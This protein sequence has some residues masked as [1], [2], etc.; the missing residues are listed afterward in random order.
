MENEI[1]KIKI[2]LPFSESLRNS[3]Y[4]A[5]I[6]KILKAEESADI[7]NLEDDHP[8]IMFGPRVESKDNEEVPPFYVSL[9]IHD[10]ILH[11]TMLESNASHNL[12]PNVS[13]IIWD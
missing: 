12:M 1:S 9:R 7:V 6:S 10:Q 13:W 5:Q 2:S 3:E 8:T 4:R 11:N